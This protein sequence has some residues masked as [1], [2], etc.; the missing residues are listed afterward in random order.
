MSG[1]SASP[2]IAPPSSIPSSS[3]QMNESDRSKPAK[4]P[5]T[6]KSDFS[7]SFFSGHP[8]AVE[9]RSIQPTDFHTSSDMVPRI[10]IISISQP[11]ILR[12]LPRKN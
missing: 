10:S 4:D 2:S 6:I 7:I 3:S 5:P 8:T 9:A 12:I 11:Y 1:S